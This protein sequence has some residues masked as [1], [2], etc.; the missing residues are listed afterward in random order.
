MTGRPK[1]RAKRAAEAEAAAQQAE[2]QPEVQQ[3][4][5]PTTTPEVQPEAPTT[6]LVPSWQ[7]P[8]MPQGNSLATTHGG[9]SDR[10]VG[11]VA[12]RLLAAVLAD[13][14]CGYLH[15]SRYRPALAAW[16]A[17]EAR[18]MVLSTFVD[19]LTLEAAAASDRGRT[20]YL[21]LLR[22][23]EA[24]ALANRG[25]LGLD[26]LSRARLGKDVASQQ[27]DVV[28]VLTALRA[29]QEAADRAAASGP[30]S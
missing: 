16:A 19:G 3:D 6:D 5:A 26:P 21:E 12:D 25:R 28:Q 27:A 29:Q 4:A 15:A 22:Q 30:T 17:A 10:V 13:P 11:P 14:E 20:S 2:V 1:T 18:V 7:R 24:S 8:P 9:Y 23:W